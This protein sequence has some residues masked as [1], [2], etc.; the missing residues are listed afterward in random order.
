MLVWG[1]FAISGDVSTGGRYNPSTDSWIA[2]SITNAPSRRHVHT[3]VWTGS[4]MIV[5]GGAVQS[6]NNSGVLN[7]G[8]RYD[9]NTDSWRATST[10]NA[11]TPRGAHTA[12]W[13]GSE[14]IVWGGDGNNF[15]RLNTGGRYCA[16][17]PTLTMLQPNGG[18]IWAAGSIQE[19]TWDSTNMNRSD[20]LIIQ[21]SRDGGASWFRIAQDV[22]AFTFGYWWHVDNFPTT[23]G[24]IKILLQEN[25]SITDQSDANFTVDRP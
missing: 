6:G 20:H 8:G 15:S 22:P 23:Q 2:T 18:E 14:M 11:P 10:N 13:T 17:L 24:R 21:Y 3:A 9:P 1:G 5:W 25:L 4:E 7:T 16:Q 19:I 12:V